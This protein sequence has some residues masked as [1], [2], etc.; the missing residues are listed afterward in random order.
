[1]ESGH[2]DV[3][4]KWLRGEFAMP[5]IKTVTTAYRFGILPAFIGFV[6]IAQMSWLWAFITLF[7]YAIAG[8]TLLKC[9][10]CGLATSGRVRTDRNGRERRSRMHHSSNPDYCSRCGLD[11]R[12]HRFAERFD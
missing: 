2:D 5:S 6:A 7:G 11:F 12:T 4:M 9:P 1:M 3:R 10:R 8:P